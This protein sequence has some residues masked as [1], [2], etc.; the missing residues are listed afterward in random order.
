MAT[1]DSSR[2]GTARG[3]DATTQRS[4]GATGRTMQGVGQENTEL[5]GRDCVRIGDILFLHGVDVEG[6]LFAD[7]FVDEC[8]WLGK[9]KPDNDHE[10]VMSSLFRICVRK[11]HRAREMLRE[12]E[13]DLPPTVTGQDQTARKFHNAEHEKLMLAEEAENADNERES[14]RSLGSIVHYGDNI[15]LEHVQSG[16]ILSI[17]RGNT[18]F[19]TTRNT[20]FEAEDTKTN[21][22]DEADAMHDVVVT[23]EESETSW[24]RVEPRFCVQHLSDP[25][26]YG[27]CVLLVSTTLPGQ[28]LQADHQPVDDP[29]FN[30][31]EFRQNDVHT[32]R[33]TFAWKMKL[34]TPYKAE[35]SASIEGGE[36]VRLQHT[37]S[38]LFVATGDADGDDDG[39]DLGNLYLDDES[40]GSYSY[41]RIELEDQ[42]SG[43]TAEYGMVV[44]LRHLLTEQYLCYSKRGVALCKERGLVAERDKTLLVLEPVF[45]ADGAMKY[46][47]VCHFKLKTIGHFLHAGDNLLSNRVRQV[48]NWY[49]ST[50][51]AG[52]KVQLL[53][54]RIACGRLGLRHICTKKTPLQSYR[55]PRRP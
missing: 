51:F 49:K 40:C 52:T 11:F 28:I 5:S 54:R 1:P 26:R 41:W 38:Q 31:E 46:N 53:T 4:I 37:E 17:C 43:A 23:N 27:E 42:F 10:L 30:G 15:E 14:K 13:K 9:A 19:L 3:G 25:V 45:M 29:A 32:F 21:V 2:A 16:K 55:W 36:V 47:C 20:E 18:E 35:A 8:C 6:L 39:N 22:E 24:F 48:S 33:D 44:R 50:C 7:G 12:L 34:F